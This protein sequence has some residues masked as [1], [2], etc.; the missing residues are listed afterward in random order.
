MPVGSAIDCFPDS[1]VVGSDIDGRVGLATGTN[2]NIGNFTGVR[3]N[4]LICLIGW[5]LSVNVKRSG[6]YRTPQ[7]TG[8]D[9][10]L[11]EVDHSLPPQVRAGL[12]FGIP[13]RPEKLAHTFPVA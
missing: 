4:S 6:A 7:Y 8:V 12:A 9:V 3:A 10:Q 1:A 13:P 11:K 2:R 5:H